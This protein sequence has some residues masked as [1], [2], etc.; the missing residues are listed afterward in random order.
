M[1]WPITVVDRSRAAELPATCGAKPSSAKAARLSSYDSPC[2]DPASS[3]LYTD[4]GSRF[5]ARRWASATVSN[6]APT[7][8]R[9]FSRG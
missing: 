1:V 6:H 8:G 4:G 2:S 7:S 5:F 3:A 9:S